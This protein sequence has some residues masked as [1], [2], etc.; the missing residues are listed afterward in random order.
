MTGK[1]KINLKIDDAT[2]WKTNN[3]NTHI[4]QYLKK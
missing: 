3:Y 4:A 2:K 1:D